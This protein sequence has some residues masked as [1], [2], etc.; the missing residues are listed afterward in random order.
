MPR[1]NNADAP[2]LMRIYNLEKAYGQA[3]GDRKVLT[4]I[5]ASSSAGE[6]VAIRGRSGSGKTTLLNLIAGLD[7][8]DPGSGD[9]RQLHLLG[10]RG[11]NS[12][13]ERWRAGFGLGVC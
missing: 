2:G 3:N 7:T 8:P 5:N 1:E 10:R 13:S 11:C 4:G 9:E 12:G 6:F